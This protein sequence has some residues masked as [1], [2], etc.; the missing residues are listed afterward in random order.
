MPGHRPSQIQPGSL[1]R[2]H[3]CLATPQGEGG[4]AGHHQHLE[5]TPPVYEARD[6]DPPGLGCHVWHR[7][8][9]E[10]SLDMEPIQPKQLWRPPRARG[11]AEVVCCHDPRRPVPDWVHPDHWQL[12]RLQDWRHQW[13]LPSYPQRHHQRGSSSLSDIVPPPWWAW[14]CLQPGCLG[15][16]QF[17]RGAGAEHLWILHFVHIQRAAAEVEAE[18]VG[19]EL[20]HRMLVHQPAVVVGSGG[21]WPAGLLVYFIL[22]VSVFVFCAPNLLIVCVWLTHRCGRLHANGSRLPPS[23]INAAKRVFAHTPCQLPPISLPIPPI[24]TFLHHSNEHSPILYSIAGLGIAI[25]NKFKR[26]IGSY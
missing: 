16:A 15:R 8:I 20:H 18:W 6:M 3:G 19:G 4:I 25:I 26:R 14:H 22:W 1:R 7:S 11:H 5:D 10:L 2:I 24:P 21:I 23:T 12:V 13:A 9:R 17:S